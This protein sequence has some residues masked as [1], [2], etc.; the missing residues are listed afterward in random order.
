MSRSQRTLKI[1]IVSI[2]TIA[3]FYTTM[4]ITLVARAG[5]DFWIGNTVGAILIYLY[6]FYLLYWVPRM[7]AWHP[8]PNF[9]TIRGRI[10]N[11]EL[12]IVL[13]VAVLAIAQ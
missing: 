13:C 9:M 5:I 11:V 3:W 10:L 6:S 12:L 8:S 2:V 4:V 1:L 7:F